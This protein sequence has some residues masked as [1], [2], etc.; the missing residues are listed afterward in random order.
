MKVF[1]G[2]LPNY[3]ERQ[4]LQRMFCQYGKINNIWLFH[5]PP[6][7]A[8]IAFEN[9]KDGHEAIREMN[10]TFFNGVKIRVEKALH[11]RGKSGRGQRKRR[12]SCDVKFHQPFQDGGKDSSPVGPR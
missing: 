6:K 11:K 8:F 10:G 4:Q 12:M 9:S 2:G 7:Y 3:I 1:V 5:S